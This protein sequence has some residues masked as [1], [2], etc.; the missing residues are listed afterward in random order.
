VDLRN[1]IALADALNLLWSSGL[2]AVNRTFRFDEYAKHV[3]IVLAQ[4]TRDAAQRTGSAGANHDGIDL[5]VHLFND[6]ARG[7]E[8]MKT[9]V[10]IILKLLRDETA[11]DG[12]REFV[13]AVNRALHSRFVRDVFK[14][15][16]ERFN[17]LH[18]L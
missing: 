6:L 14:L 15:A 11:V 8:F 17:Q 7:R 5:A 13:A 4:R 1:K 9:R 10:R 3:A 12:G 18:L 2:A 16:A